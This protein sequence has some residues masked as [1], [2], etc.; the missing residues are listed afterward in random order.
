MENTYY[1]G[2][3][4]IGKDEEPFLW[5]EGMGQT[6]EY[7]LRMQ[8]DLQHKKLLLGSIRHAEFFLQDQ[9]PEQLR[10]VVKEIQQQMGFYISK[11]EA[12]DQ[13]DKKAV[14]V[15]MVHKAKD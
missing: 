15:T 1:Y 2:V 10:F 9:M 12:I 3:K 13:N 11:V 14:E 6:V 4:L 7:N 5:I 8:S